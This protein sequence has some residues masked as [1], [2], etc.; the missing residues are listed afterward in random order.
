MIFINKKIGNQ[1]W[2]WN[3]RDQRSRGTATSNF[4]LLPS[5]ILKDQEPL[6]ALPYYFLSPICPQSPKLLWYFWFTNGQLCSLT[7]NNP[8]Y[9]N[10]IKIPH[11]TLR[12]FIA[13]WLLPLA[14]CSFPLQMSHSVC[15]SASCAPNTTQLHLHHI[16]QGT[17]TT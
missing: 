15:I 11:N 12:L 13:L 3:L 4:Y 6:S 16:M 7:T 2:G 8:Y 10:M 5:S 1:I 17:L 9:Q 14:I